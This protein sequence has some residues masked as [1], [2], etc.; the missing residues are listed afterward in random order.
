[1]LHAELRRL[2]DWH[3]S[4]ERANHTLQRTELVNEAY[5]R[6][7]G[8]EN[9]NYAT[10]SHFL[11]AAAQTMRR[12][13]VEHAR[14]RGS[15]K[16]GG[17]WNK[18]AID[19]VELPMRAGKM[20]QLDVMWLDEVLERLAKHNPRICDVVVGRCFAGMTVD[21]VAEAMGISPRT[22]A[23]YWSEGKKW[24]SDELDR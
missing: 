10:Q 5:L 6:L 12:I 21:E 2:A 19:D 11:A 4:R 3:M 24:L 14:T 18:L 22:V 15:H 8:Q 20:G 13:L 7:I 23:N 16:R 17:G 1:E 9:L